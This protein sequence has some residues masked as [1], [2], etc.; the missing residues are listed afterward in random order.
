MFRHMAFRFH[1]AISDDE[2]SEQAI[3]RVIDDVQTTFDAA[4]VGFLFYTPHHRDQLEEMAEKILLEYEPAALIGCSCEGVIGGE[5][6][7]ERAPGLALLMGTMPGARIHPFHIATDDW[8]EVIASETKLRESM[9]I[10]PE[11]RGVI[12]FG[13]PWT[14]PLNQFLQA[15][16]AHAP[17]APLVGGF[18]SGA[19]APGENRL[20]NG[21][22]VRE[23]GF[24]GVSI[25][26]DVEMLTVVSQGCKPIGQPMVI[27]KGRENIIEQL[28]GRPSMTVLREMID[29]LSEG[30]REL[31][32]N[33][34]LIGRAI[35]EYREKFGRGDFLVRN[36]AGADQESG[37]VQVADYVRVGQTVQFHVRDAVCAD[38]DLS[39]MLAEDRIGKPPAGGLLFSCN[40]RG[41]NLFDQPNHDIR[42]AH[43]KMPRAPIAGFFA[44]G[45]IGPVGGKNFIHGHTASFA[46]FREKW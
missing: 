17:Q 20:L 32:R 10:G 9:G 7:I 39:L 42:V 29:T 19:R 34:L 43:E 33:G 45:E 24:V 22:S 21:D 46:L 28:G 3:D 36:L 11:T 13:D 38:E 15:M 18:A 25:S 1:S 6:E 5:R 2:S 12:G 26:G 40:G 4:D 30:D 27:T 23:D 44:A 8:R 16:D 14:T 35:S 31:L 41:T 37:A